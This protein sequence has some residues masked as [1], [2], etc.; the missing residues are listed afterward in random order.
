VS[1]WRITS[2]RSSDLQGN[3]TGL[4]TTVPAGVGDPCGTGTTTT[5]SWSYDLSS[6]VL[7]AGDGAGQYS[8][9]PLGQITTM[10]AADAPHPAGGD[11]ALGYFDSGAPRS[12]TQGG[13]S[14]AFTLDVSGR[15]LVETT[16]ED[17]A[18]TSTLTRHYTDGSDSPSW[19]VEV[20][21][22]V[23]EL[24]RYTPALG[25]GLGAVVLPDGTV[26]LS[27]DDPHGDIVTTVTV[28]ESGNA[29]GI[30][31][32]STFDEYGNPTSG[33][34][35]PVTADTGAASYGWLGSSERA[36]LGVGLILMGARVYNPVTGRF[37]SPDP[38][39]GGNENPYSAS[40]PSCRTRIGHRVS[41]SR[42]T[43][44]KESTSASV[45]SKAHIQR[46]SPPARSQS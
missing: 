30:T 16:T 44:T 5:K 34:G 31:G 41:S 1:S 3:R 46:T 13:V 4:S 43:S 15:R 22:G 27:L 33:A 14:T 20:A 10:P 24:T 12:V 39:P 36:V 23:T 26:E 9:D 37:G 11:I 29:T 7:T 8:Y 21:S 6:R 28:P 32:W 42:I 18:I 38:V 25:S 19:I 35:S 17:E 45:V 40:R 2:A